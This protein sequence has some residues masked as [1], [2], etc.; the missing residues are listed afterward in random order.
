M[1]RISNSVLWNYS[2][3]INIIVYQ[4]INLF[5]G[6]PTGLKKTIDFSPENQLVH[7]KTIWFS[8]KPPPD[9]GK[10]SDVSG[11]QNIMHSYLAAVTSG[12]PSLL[13]FIPCG[14]Y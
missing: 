3:V 11:G 6:K 4:K 7:W 14:L 1:L 5:T 13:T 9:R 2:E 10:L 12:V 8:E